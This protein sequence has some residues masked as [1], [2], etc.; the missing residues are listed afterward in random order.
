[1]RAGPSSS[2]WPCSRVAGAVAFGYF[3][4]S[5][6]GRP[7]PPRFFRRWLWARC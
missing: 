5:E 4:L 3:G 2:H 6:P 7:M 1:M